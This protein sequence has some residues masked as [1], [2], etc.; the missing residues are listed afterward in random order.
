MS[1]LTDNWQID[2]YAI[3]Q[4]KEYEGHK[5][6]SA[7]KEGLEFPEDEDEKKKLEDDKAAYEE[8]TKTVK[9][10]LGDKVEKV[11]ISN[12]ISDSPCV[13]VTA[14]F[15]WSANMERIMKAQALR[16]TN[17]TSYMVAKKVILHRYHSMSRN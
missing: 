9:E 7:A 1:G 15:G 13:L 16:D 10:I 11:V 14:A 8:L 17:M 6:Q 4:L 12:R 2:E 5:L 3:P